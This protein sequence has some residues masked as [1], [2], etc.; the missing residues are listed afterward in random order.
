[1]IGTKILHHFT[2][3]SEHLSYYRNIPKGYSRN[4]YEEE[5]MFTDEWKD[6][7]RPGSFLYPKTFWSRTKKDQNQ[8]FQ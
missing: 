7:Q 3:L 4:T 6:G 5:K 2:E 8:Y 1:M